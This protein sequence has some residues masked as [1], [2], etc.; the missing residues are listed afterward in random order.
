M[1]NSKGERLRCRKQYPHLAA[2]L[3]DTFSESRPSIDLD[4]K[5]TR[6]K[7]VC[8]TC[9]TEELKGTVLTLEDQ[10]NARKDASPEDSQGVK[11]ARK[12]I[13]KEAAS[14]IAA[15][16][17]TLSILN[18]HDRKTF[19]ENLAHPELEN[20][21]APSD[22]AN[23]Q[24]FKELFGSSHYGLWA[25]P[26]E[27]AGSPAG[28]SIGKVTVPEAA[29]RLEKG[30]TFIRMLQEIQA[31]LPH[32]DGV[33]PPGSLIKMKEAVRQQM[34]RVKPLE[35]HVV[36]KEEDEGMIKGEEKA[37]PEDSNNDNNGG[38]DSP[39][40]PSGS[41]DE[42][43]EENKGGD[44]AAPPADPAPRPERSPPS[45]PTLN[46]TPSPSMAPAAPKDNDAGDEPA[47][48]EWNDPEIDNDAAT[49][50]TRTSGR[51]CTPSVSS[52]AET[53][54]DAPQ[55]AGN[56]H[57]TPGKNAAR[58]KRKQRQKKKKE[59]KQKHAL[60]M[61]EGEI[62]EPEKPKHLEPP[63]YDPKKRETIKKTS[64]ELLD[65][66]RM[67]VSAG[68]LAEMVKEQERK[69]GII[70]MSM[71]DAL[72]AKAR[73]NE[74]IF[75]RLKK[76]PQQLPAIST[77]PNLFNP[78]PPLLVK[79]PPSGHPFD[80]GTVHDRAVVAAVLTDPA[81]GLTTTY[82]AGKHFTHLEVTRRPGQSIQGA[83]QETQ[84]R[85]RALKK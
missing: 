84:D 39:S 45:S 21:I 3:R 10:K 49:E 76:Q 51:V 67:G 81:L 53:L 74:G 68:D 83:L 13:G 14:R 79:P 42:G 26:P 71:V 50:S 80:T 47:G 17:Q 59:Q 28:S 35:M 46:S 32:Q 37:T 64:R 85:L 4:R 41:D 9:F 2:L 24:Y 1:F 69:H 55:H 16:R 31:K 65:V 48:W 56:I 75:E 5:H 62:R 7:D 30:K 11:A 60:E 8:S 78:L 61:E 82:E 27:L 34:E 52:H 20:Y 12:R 23:S 44:A 54:V 58:N 38:S 36:Y 57:R 25:A 19:F 77:L 66:V 73:E 29:P 15:S 63:E 18:S 33:L 40:G 43:D 70:G 6:A 72:K 22:L